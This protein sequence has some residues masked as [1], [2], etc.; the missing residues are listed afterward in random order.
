MVPSQLA[1]RVVCVRNVPN[2][3]D[4]SNIFVLHSGQYLTPDNM[5]IEY[6]RIDIS[7]VA[8]RKNP[9][10]VART[11][12]SAVKFPGMMTTLIALSSER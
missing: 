10:H 5:R 7:R 6:L 3:D 11:T 12:L 1:P 2:I 9:E 8:I 4:H